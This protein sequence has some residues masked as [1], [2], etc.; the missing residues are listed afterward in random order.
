[1]KRDLDL[2]RKLLLEAEKSEQRFFEIGELEWFDHDM[3]DQMM[4]SGLSEEELFHLDLMEQGNLIRKSHD[5]N[6]PEAVYGVC[7]GRGQDRT[8]AR[9][10]GFDISGRILMPDRGNR[11]S[12]RPAI[13]LGACRRT[14]QR[15]SHSRTILR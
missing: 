14:L 12:F 6:F 4:R 11:P 13:A 5:P 10:P 15:A 7:S 2:V 3:S 8:L 1:V 9:V